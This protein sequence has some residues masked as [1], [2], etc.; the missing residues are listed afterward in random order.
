MTLKPLTRTSHCRARD[1]SPPVQQPQRHPGQR[2]GHRRPDPA[3]VER[4]AVV[5]ALERCG[6]NQTHAARELGI[7]RWALIRLMQKYGLK[8]PPRSSR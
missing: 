6:G 3:E 7:S 8:K 5:A 1:A 2:C 4:D